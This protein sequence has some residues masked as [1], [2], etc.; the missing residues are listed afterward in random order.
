MSSVTVG[1]STRQDKSDFVAYLKETSGIKDLHVIQKINNGEKSLSQV[2]NEILNESV[3]DYV[4]LCH[5]DILFEK[6]YWAKRVSEHFQKHSDYGILGVAGTSYMSSTG[7]WWAI[8]SEMIGQVHHQHEGRKWL[9]K[10]SE[11]FGDR[12]VDSVVVDGLFMAINKKNI[13]KNF[14][15]SVD[16]FHFY[17]INFCFQNFLEGV[18][19]GTISNIP[20]TH[21]SIGMTNEKWEKNRTL[22]VEKFKDSLPLKLVSKYKDIKMNKK[23]PLVSVVIPIY[24]YGQQFEKTLQSVFNSKYQNIEVI[25]VNDGSTDEYVLNKLK[26]LESIDFVKIIHTEN[27][28]P[29]KA[30]N[31]GVKNSSGQFILPLDADDQIDPDYISSCVTILK[32]NKNISPVYC[33]TNH[34]GEI[35]GPEKRPEWTFERLKQGPFIVNCSMFHKNAFDEV[36]GYDE[37]LKGWEDYDLWIRMAKKGYEGKRIPKFLFTYFHHEKDGTVSTEANV[38]Q[39]ELYNKI[40]SKNFGQ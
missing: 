39:Q 24:N 21:L 9:S 37:E 8:Q 32:N 29:S 30:R 3:S 17:D 2:Y 20:I 13:K 22:F 15:E 35:R 34:V 1:F 28:G 4:I 12:I 23:L 33:D 38:N 7:C 26:S 6:N 27:G 40:M 11:L 5:D 25:I 31:I 14:D 10:Y 16:G 18:K 36:G 19:I